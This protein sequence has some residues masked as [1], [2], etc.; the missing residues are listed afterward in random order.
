VPNTITI[1]NVKTVTSAT[2]GT[3]K[4]LA[5]NTITYSD[6]TLATRSINLLLG[7]FVIFAFDTPTTTNIT[8]LTGIYAQGLRDANSNNALTAAAIKRQLQIN[9][10]CAV[11]KGAE[12]I[13]NFDKN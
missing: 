10:C 3:I 1:G 6:A 12:H 11:K 5:G 4:D 2:A 7:E 13:E 8:P 9:S